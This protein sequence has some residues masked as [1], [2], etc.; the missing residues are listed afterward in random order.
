MLPAVAHEDDAGAYPFG[1]IK[2]LGHVPCAELAGLIDKDDAASRRF[3]HLL[4]LQEPG[5]GIGLLEA[6]FLTQHFPAGLH[7]LG[8]C[9]HGLTGFSQC[10]ADLLFERRFS[11]SGDTAD[12]HHPVAGAEH[13]AHG[14][15]LSV[16]EPITRA[17]PVR[18]PQRP[19]SPAPFPGKVD[20]PRLQGQHFFCGRHCPPLGIA[21]D[22]WAL[23][24]LM[25][26]PLDR[27]G[28]DATFQGF[29][30]Q[31]AFRHHRFAHETMLDGVI[32]S[33][34]LAMF[35]HGKST[36]AAMNRRQRI[37]FRVGQAGVPFLA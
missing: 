4:I 16:V 29:G 17:W 12:Y 1:H 7:R 28:A 30:V 24:D 26:H 25:R 22:Q 18:V 20:Q 33:Q 31:L 3:L 14:R 37:A 36:F 9:N 23:A 27:D 19:E 8:Q 32:D 34:P 10:F 35:R 11:R 5:H 21:A 15:L 2:H 6:C 13:V